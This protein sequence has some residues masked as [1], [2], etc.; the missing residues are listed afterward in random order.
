MDRGEGV[1]T[2]VL[3]GL[4]EEAG[5]VQLEKGLVLDLIC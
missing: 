1:G 2:P 4:A 5:L 3:R